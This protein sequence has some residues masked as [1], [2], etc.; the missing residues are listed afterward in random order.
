VL[1]VAT[2]KVLKTD[3]DVFN[4]GVFPG[5]PTEQV[6]VSVNEVF[7]FQLEHDKERAVTETELEREEEASD[8]S[9]EP[10]VL[11]IEKTFKPSQFSQKNNKELLTT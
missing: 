6:K 1:D 8:S 2:A 9:E 4:E 5:K 10:V 11:Q 7:K 3:S